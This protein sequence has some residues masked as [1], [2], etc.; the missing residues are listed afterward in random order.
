MQQ[1]FALYHFLS[2]A[3]SFF[4]A[5]VIMFL[6]QEHEEKEWFFPP[7]LVKVCC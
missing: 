1:V 2:R 3:S 5:S 6:T 7:Q 4:K